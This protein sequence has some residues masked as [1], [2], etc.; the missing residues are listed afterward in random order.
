MKLHQAFLLFVLF[1][2]CK[3]ESIVTALEEA[4]SDQIISLDGHTL[5]PPKDPKKVAVEKD[6]NLRLAHIEY[7]NHP[8]SLQAHIWYGRRLAN[9]YKYKEAISVYTSAIDSFPTSPE[10]YRHRGHRYI[11]TRQFDKAIQDLQK[12]SE[13]VAGLPIQTEPDGI[14]NRINKPLSNLQFNI[15]YHWGL[16]YFMKGDFENARIKLD[17]CLM[18]SDNPDLKVATVDWLYMTHN[19]LG[20]KDLAN[21]VLNHVN[22]D[23]I[24][25]EN[26]AYFKRIMMY[27]GIFKPEDI[28]DPNKNKTANKMDLITQG[29]GVAQ[30]HAKNG[31]AD[32]S[33][34]V[35]QKIVA[36]D[37]W[38]AF[39][40]IAAEAE[41]LRH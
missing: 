10:L 36:S 31:Q 23:M 33:K 17:S 9:V 2:C 15:W 20:Q 40:Y 32:L 30:W 3:Q 25:V 41:L 28:L 37:Y 5:T 16:A 39:G 22:K 14:P 6:A 11:T 24:M 18:Y 4:D 19:K 12:A 8:D 34:M 13:L 7:N 27:K 1:T 29:F 35:L 21:E 26:D 38:Q